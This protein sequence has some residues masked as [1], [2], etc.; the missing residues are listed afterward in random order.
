[1][2]TRLVKLTLSSEFTDAFRT[3]FEEVKAAIRARKGCRYLDLLADVERPNVFFTYSIWD[4]EEDLRAYVESDLFKSIWTEV[5][6]M[7]AD[8]TLAWSTKPVSTTG[9]VS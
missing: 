3:N 9:P 4:S 7:L 5:K 2:I 6:P 8:K 1:M